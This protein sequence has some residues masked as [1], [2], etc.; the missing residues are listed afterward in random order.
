MCVIVDRPFAMPI[1][2]DHPIARKEA[3]VVGWPGSS[4]LEIEELMDGIPMTGQSMTLLS[5]CAS[6]TITLAY[7][8]ALAEKTGIDPKEVY[9]GVI[10]YPF[11]NIFGQ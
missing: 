6:S 2:S 7:I 8:V 3:G 11:S 5:S 10:A 9:G 1:D 4:P